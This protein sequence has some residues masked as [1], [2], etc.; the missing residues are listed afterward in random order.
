VDHVEQGVSRRWPLGRERVGRTGRNGRAICSQ[1]GVCLA[2]TAFRAGSSGRPKPVAT[3]PRRP[4]QPAP[5]RPRRLPEPQARTVGHGNVSPFRPLQRA[6]R[7]ASG[8]RISPRGAPCP[9]PPPSS[10]ES[11]CRWEVTQ[12]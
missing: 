6:V 9:D 1:G 5:S 4:C 7:V 11:S 2:V 8:G 3:V 10:G 12:W